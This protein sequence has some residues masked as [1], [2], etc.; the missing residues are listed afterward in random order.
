MI[1]KDNCDFPI[2]LVITWVD[3]SDSRHKARRRRYSA[4]GTEMKFDDVGGDTRFNSVGEIF[5]CVASY[6]RF[7]PYIRKIFIVT[8]SQDPC[9]E[10]FLSEYFSEEELPQIE[11]VDHKAIFRGYESFLPVFNSLAIETMLWRIPDLSEHFI[12]SNDDVFLI[13]PTQVED[14]FTEGKANAYGYWHLAWTARF[15]R[16]VRRSVN[17]HKH[18]S[19]R[20]SML[21]SAILRN[22]MRFYR[23]EHT[24]HAMRKSILKKYFQKHP[25]HMISNISHRFRHPSQFNPQVLAYM[26]GVKD[27][28]VQTIDSTGKYKYLAPKRD[29]PSDYV[30]TKIEQFMQNDKPKFLCVNSLDQN[31]DQER[32]AIES[33]IHKCLKITVK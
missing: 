15:L 23:I 17:N 30:E 2:D 27:G 22:A 31:T 21:N 9:L 19:F 14:F 25:E 13:R 1:G 6:I 10:P 5:Y 8:D 12:Y 28:S 4:E 33:Y 11:I 29:R 32:A 26:L 24:P 20:D 7:A 3:G 18:F 16:K